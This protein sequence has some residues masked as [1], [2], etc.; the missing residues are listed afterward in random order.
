MTGSAPA[1][2]AA[3]ICTSSRPG[4]SRDLYGAACRAVICLRRGTV[5]RGKAI[6]SPMYGEAMLHVA[7]ALVTVRVRPSSVES[8]EPDQQHDEKLP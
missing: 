2:L 6:S 5:T 8:G 7:G 1:R 4:L 3:T